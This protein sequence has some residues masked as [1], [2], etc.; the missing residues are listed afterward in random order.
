MIGKAFRHRIARVARAKRPPKPRKKPLPTVVI[1][2]KPPRVKPPTHAE[3]KNLL[4]EHGKAVSAPTLAPEAVAPA[5]RA[6]KELDA[7]T[8]KLTSP[9]PPKRR[10]TV[11][12]PWVKAKPAPTPVAPKGRVWHGKYADLTKPPQG[13]P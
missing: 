7:V 9:P 5:A 1:P 3:A 13:E 10:R 2:P 8:K 6:Y 4:A 11:N 12:L